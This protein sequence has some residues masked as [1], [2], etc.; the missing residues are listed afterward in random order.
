M[1]TASTCRRGG[2]D[3]SAPVQVILARA[4]TEA[5]RLGPL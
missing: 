3:G 5:T 4:G 2:T 1:P